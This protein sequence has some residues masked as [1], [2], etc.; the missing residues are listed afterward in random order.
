M[1]VYPFERLCTHPH[2]QLAEIASFQHADERFGRV[3]KT[4]DDV[5]AITDAV[6]GDAGT[7]LT[8]ECGIVFGGEIHS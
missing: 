5:L 2:D 4:V 7:D 1:C 3:L 6:V 8:Q